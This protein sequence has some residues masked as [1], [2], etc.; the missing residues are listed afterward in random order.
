M[1]N[2][3]LILWA[4]L[5]LCLFG[6]TLTPRQQEFYKELNQRFARL[7]TL[8]DS[9]IDVLVR[10][11][12]IR[13]RAADSL[14]SFLKENAAMFFELP[15][16]ADFNLVYLAKSADHNLCLV[17]WDTRLGGTLI[18]FATLLCYRSASGIEARLL[19][20]EMEDNTKIHYDKV[21][22]LTT[23][24]GRNIYL[25]HGFGQGSVALPWQDVRAFA[26]ENNTLAMP[27]V[28]PGAQNRMFLEFDTQEFAEGE[29]VP[30]VRWEKGGKVIKVPARTESGGVTGKYITIKFNGSRFQ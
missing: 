29:A 17:S 21:Y 13:L 26:I 11:P 2:L 16:S 25:A 8:R 3:I 9:N 12:D 4:F 1:K 24:D 30:V 22:T 14:A 19:L 18:D 15:D 7:D 10:D 28:F 27:A 23:G 5:P 20:D 6:Q